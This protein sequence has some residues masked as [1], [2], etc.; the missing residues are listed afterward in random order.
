VAGERPGKL[1]P[2]LR[3][4]RGSPAGLLAYHDTR[5]PEAY[6][7]LLFYPDVFRRLVRAYRVA[8]AGAG[9]AVTHEFEF[10]K[11]ADPLFRPCQML[12][13]PDGAVY[14]VDWRT[15]SGGAG[16]LSG[17]GQHGRIYRLTWDGLPTRGRDSWAK[18]L[19]L[20]DA[21]LVA[22][23]DRPDLTDRV[24]AR[25]ELVRRGETA[26]AR[27]LAAF[28][29]GRLGPHG[30]LAAVGV[31]QRRWSPAVADLFRH[32]LADPSADVRRLAC[33]ALSQHGPAPLATQAALA[34]SL[35]DADPAVRRAAA[36][37]LGRVGATLAAGRLAAAWAADP[38]RDPFLADAYLRGL[39]HLGKPGVDAVLAL[40]ATDA[41]R[42]R[43]VAAFAGFR[44][45][46]AAD[47]LPALLAD[48]RLTTG[49]QVE[50]VRSAGNYQLLPPLSFDPLID[51]VTRLAPPPAV[52]AA[53]LE[54]LALGPVAGDRPA[55]YVLA[56]LSHPDPAVRLAALKVIEDQR[57]TVA[58]GPL[59]DLLTDG[60]RPPDE[61]LAI[62]RAMGAAS[63]SEVAPRLEQLLA[64][65]GPSA[66]KVEALRALATAAPAVGRS[67]AD[68][69][70]ASPDPAVQAEAVSVAATS[71]GGAVRA[72]ELFLAGRLPAAV[73]PRVS[74]GVARFKA[75]PACAALAER[76]KAGRLVLGNDPAT[77]KTVAAQ[78][79]QQGDPAR[80][81]AVF[82]D[83]N[84]VAC[85]NC[86]KLEGTGNSVGPDLTRVWESH[87]PV[88]LVE[89]IL[90]PSKEIKE[91]YQAV[92]ATLAD[93]RV[94]VGLAVSETGQTVVLRDG[95]GRDVRLARADIEQYG[96]TR[97]S[98]MPADSFSRL[99]L[100]QFLDLL[101][102]LR[103][104][105]QQDTLRVRK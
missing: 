27:T 21:E 15:D 46:P 30:R 24:E 8:P 98:L 11:S 59:P 17:D 48:R 20:P 104:Q 91:G 31:L 26:H 28:T 29:G 80:G 9:F 22:A 55:G 45:R 105:E 81:K 41:G 85:V 14:V 86:H 61:R 95:E 102:F 73:L 76:L 79:E 34:K 63:P 36:V 42:A 13:G 87:S 88:K 43:A 51:A 82:L 71:R 44:T 6:R 1:P 66:E 38:G 68:R 54:V 3:T 89:S 100:G 96:P 10:L 25:K 47:A 49:Q 101:A 75:D 65:P 60:S 23:L 19:K 72:A 64:G 83:G 103:S 90:D 78:I 99:T 58:A 69:L 94:V 84:L 77:V 74:A 32:L 12:T 93:G 40:A 16:R 7:G 62:L 50:L 52:R 37:A 70:L 39:E 92:Q 5:A 35:A 57:L 18:L 97:L 4:G 53:V 33:D 67:A 2:M 56:H